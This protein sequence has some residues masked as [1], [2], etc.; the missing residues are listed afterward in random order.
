MNLRQL[1]VLVVA[2][3]GVAQASAGVLTL[4]F[5]AA[6][7][8]TIQDGAG[9]GTGFT[10][11]LGGT[12]GS[13][14]ANDP[15]M[16]LNTGSGLLSLTSTN[17]D[18]NGQSNLGTG[19]YIG[20]QLSTLGFTGSEDFT[21]ATVISG[22]TGNVQVNQQFGLVVGASSAFATR[23]GLI[24]TSKQQIAVNTFQGSDNSAVLGGSPAAP[25]TMTVS[26]TGGVF[27]MVVNGT[28]VLPLID[29][30]FLNSYSDLF[31]GIYAASPGGELFTVSV[32]SFQVSVVPEPGMMPIGA[33]ISLAAAAVWRRR[34]RKNPTSPANA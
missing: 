6:V 28:S 31:A 13:L 10:A 23:M 1:V 14:P 24:G 20:V 33:G 9:A 25:W 4:D 18:L 2:L 8:G 15:N 17:S 29:A 34:R 27:D 3:G 11:R 32:D 19:E 22:F 16:S 26:R 30:G 7:P 21:V 5:T 12:G